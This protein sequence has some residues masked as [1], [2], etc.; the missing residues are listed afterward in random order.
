[1]FKKKGNMTIVNN[2]NVRTRAHDAILFITVKPNN[3]KCKRSVLYKRA[4][5]WNSLPVNERNIEKYEN[6]KTV[7]KKKLL[8]ILN[9]PQV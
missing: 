4:L 7:Q 5:S 2:R 6:F 1:M 9:V 8:T 3:E